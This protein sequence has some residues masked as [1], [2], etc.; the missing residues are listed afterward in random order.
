MWKKPLSR[1]TLYNSRTFPTGPFTILEPQYQEIGEIFVAHKRP[2]ANFEDKKLWKGRSGVDYEISEFN[3]LLFRNVLRQI[4]KLKNCDRERFGRA[5]S[6]TGKQIQMSS[7]YWRYLQPFTAWFFDRAFKLTGRKI[8]GP[9]VF[10]ANSMIENR[11]LLKLSSFC[12]SGLPS[13]GW[14]ETFLENITSVSVFL[15]Y[16]TFFLTFPV[17]VAVPRS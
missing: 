4:L 14:C 1:P 15:H 12:E 17:F 13:Q 7:R 6:E 11:H 8:W 10:R 3:V 2:A 5:A 16:P 9:F